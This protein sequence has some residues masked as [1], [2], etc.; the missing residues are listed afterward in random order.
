[1]Y[2]SYNSCGSSGQEVHF[3]FDSSAL[4][5]FYPRDVSTVSASSFIIVVTVAF[6]GLLLICAG[7]SSYYRRRLARNAPLRAARLNGLTNSKIR[8]RLWDIY[9]ERWAG[10]E[11]GA[12]DQW[13]NIQV[14]NSTYV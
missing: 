6:V 4:H 1:M 12:A 2:A 5:T 10:Q 13:S 11:F 9:M 3:T 7:S 8:P 14:C